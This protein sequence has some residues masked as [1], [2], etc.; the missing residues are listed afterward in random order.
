MIPEFYHKIV[1][2]AIPEDYKIVVF[3]KVF[4]LKLA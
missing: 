4:S 2:T 1:P 3:K